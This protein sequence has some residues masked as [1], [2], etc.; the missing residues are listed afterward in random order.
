MQIHKALYLH[1]EQKKKNPKL[2]TDE[3]FLTEKR[4]GWWAGIPYKIGKG[5]QKPISAAN[6]IVPAWEWLAETGKLAE[7]LPP[8]STDNLIIA[9]AVIPDTPFHILNGMFN[10]SIGEY[11]CKDVEF[12]VHDIIRTNSNGLV[13]PETAKT[14]WERLQTFMSAARKSNLFQLASIISVETFDEDRWLRYFEEIYNRGGEGIVA[15]N[16]SG[17]YAPGKRNADLLKMKAEDTYDCTF[18]ELYW[19]MGEKGEKNLNIA[20]KTNDGIISNVRVGKHADIRELLE[21][22]KEGQLQ[23]A[24]IEI[25]AMQILE[26]GALREPRFK[27]IRYDLL[28]KEN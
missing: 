6:R 19:T 25:K 12:I 17:C 4:D 18:H 24:I 10:R 23:N 16:L 8:L 21:K 15:K 20:V 2:F 3:Y 22:E 13:I 1:L 14:R 27:A 11:A 28:K 26:S 5:W 9:E 7:L